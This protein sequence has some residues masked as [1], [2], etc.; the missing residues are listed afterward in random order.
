MVVR[1]E[2]HAR[3]A[4]R[5]AVIKS[6][7]VNVDKCEP[8]S[9]IHNCTNIILPSK[10]GMRKADAATIMHQQADLHFIANLQ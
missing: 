3:T 1:I 4:G 5:V 7:C 9:N 8:M 10:F 2:S 6:R